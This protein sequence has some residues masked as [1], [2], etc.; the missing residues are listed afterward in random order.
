MM[1]GAATLAAAPMSRL[2]RLGWYTPD[3]FRFMVHLLIAILAGTASLRPDPTTPEPV[4]PLETLVVPVHAPSNEGHWATT[5]E[6]RW[7]RHRTPSTPPS[8]R[9]SRRRRRPTPL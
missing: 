2:R 4:R 9:P 8:P 3:N 6:S 7:L 5:R 1:I